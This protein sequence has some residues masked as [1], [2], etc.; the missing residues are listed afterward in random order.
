MSKPIPGTLFDRQSGIL[1]ASTFV[2]PIN[3]FGGAPVNVAG[4]QAGVVTG[5]PTWSNGPYGPQ[6]GGF[7]TSDYFDYPTTLPT[8]PRWIAVMFT[9]TSTAL[10]YPIAYCNSGQTK[11]VL[12]LALNYGGTAGTAGM[13][14]T[15]NSGATYNWVGSGLPCNDGNP[16]V[17]MGWTTSG[18]QYSCAFDGV[19]VSSRAGGSV[20]INPN[21]ITLGA[22]HGSTVSSPLS[23]G[24]LI[25]A[26]AG[27]GAIP[28]YQTLYQDWMSGRFTGLSIPPTDYR[29]GSG[30]SP[31]T[32]SVSPLYG[33]GML[34]TA[35]LS[36]GTSVSPSSLVGSGVMPSPT[37]SLGAGVS[38]ASLTGSGVLS[39]VSIATDAILSPSSLIGSGTLADVTVAAGGSITVAVSALAG[40]GPIPAPA[41][42]FDWVQSAAS[43]FGSGVL[44]GVTVETGSTVSITVSA[45]PLADRARFRALAPVMI[46]FNPLRRSSAVARSDSPTLSPV[47]CTETRTSSMR[48]KRPLMPRANSTGSIGAQSRRSAATAPMT[49]GPS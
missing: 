35:G 3:E 21:Q 5:S 37:I 47:G 45:G 36:L 29:Y 30:S 14:I 12:G 48:S 15:D 27:T 49:Y 34:P 33:I 42:A 38:V 39:D 13:V 19:V 11:N 40:S 17:L 23:G 8:G 43:L 10:T 6:V 24:S 7:S 31:V 2:L 46:G 1:G 4:I 18:L 16:H 25:F 20:T 32:V 9:N 22:L 41:V 44:S 28:D 26:A